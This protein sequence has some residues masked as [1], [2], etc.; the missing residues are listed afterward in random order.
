LLLEKTLEYLYTGGY[1]F[2]RSFPGPPSYKEPSTDGTVVKPP[3]VSTRLSTLWATLTTSRNVQKDESSPTARPSAVAA[4]SDH[5]ALFHA[6]M[7]TQGEYFQIQ[8]LKRAA[9]KLVWATFMHRPDRES[10]AAIVKETYHSNP[11]HDRELREL[12]VDLMLDN[13]ETLRTGQTPALDDDLLSLAPDFTLGL[14]KV[15]VNEQLS[16]P[17]CQHCA[18]GARCNGTWPP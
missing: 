8:G 14:C 3:K 9:L 12:V 11:P 10:I 7:Y 1:T 4:F 5:P 17:H 15:L 2:P 13:A 6:M 16:R 18:H